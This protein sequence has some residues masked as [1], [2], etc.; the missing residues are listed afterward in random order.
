MN[1]LIILPSFLALVLGFICLKIKGDKKEAKTALLFTSIISIVN[2]A[3]IFSLYNESL[4]LFKFTENL[5]LAFKIDG[6][7][8]VFVILISFLWPLA[9][10]YATKYMTHE[11]HLH[12]F[13]SLYTLTYGIVVGLSFASNALTMYLFFELLT[14]V[15]FPLVS[16]HDNA[17]DRHAGKIYMQYSI[18]GAAISF[19]GLSIYI[20]YVGSFDFNFNDFSGPNNPSLYLAYVLMFVGFSVKAAIFPM[21]KWLPAAGVAPTTTTALLHA[22]AVVKSGLIAVM[23]VTYFMFDI[24]FL[25]GTIAQHTVLTLAI[26]TIVLGSSLAVKSKHLKRRFAYSTMSQLSYILLAVA[27]MST[28]G[29]TIAILHLIFHALIKIVIFYTAGNVLY[30]DHK[31]NIKDIEGYGNVMKT[32]FICFTI[33]SLSLIGIPPLGGF[34]SKIGI[35][36][37]M[38]NLNNIFGIMGIVALMISALLTAI[39]LL[40]IVFLAFLPHDDFDYSKIAKLKVPPLEMRLPLVIIT[41]VMVVLS[42][43]SNDLLKLINYLVVGGIN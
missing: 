22:V 33:S 12:R 37:S 32:T 16:F 21:Y 23:R 29:L 26:I 14:F 25:K 43:Y 2:I 18:W 24:E 36:F 9:T 15:T 27:S 28:F 11:G 34:A 40:Q 42:L 41:S 35:G 38:A 19:I 20:Y 30:V 5:I 17:R 10:L 7:A 13:F 8:S 4:V 39:Y 6:L 3:V 31:E 1:I